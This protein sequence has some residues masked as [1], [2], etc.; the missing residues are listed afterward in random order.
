M[1]RLWFVCFAL[2]TFSSFGLASTEDDLK[3]LVSKMQQ[4][5]LTQNKN[6]Y[7]ELLDLS[8]P[9]FALEHSRFV[10]DWVKNPVKH[11]ELAFAL[12][13]EKTNEAQG[14]LTW[15]YQNKDGLN[16]TSNSLVVFHKLEGRWLYAGE[17]WLELKAENISVKFVPGLES[18]AQSILERLPEVTKHVATS[19]EF[20]SQ[21]TITVKIYDSR[22]SLTQSVGLSWKVFGGWNEPGEAIKVSSRLGR[23]VSSALLAHE[24]TH[25]Y[26]FEHFG[27]R[28]FPWWLDEGLAQDVASTYWNASDVNLTLRDVKTWEADNTLE[29]WE[30][31]SDLDTTPTNL[32]DYV[33]AQGFAFV[34]FIRQIYGQHGLNLW[35]TE[36]SSSKTKSL[37]DAAQ[38]TFGKSFVTLD[39][40]FRAWLKKQTLKLL[41]VNVLDFQCMVNAVATV[42]GLGYTL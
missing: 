22:E 34:H 37:S 19:L 13:E 33:Y 8:D 26:A 38:V 4:A 41:E 2:L 27:S 14:K 23:N 40:D 29:P 5:V 17:Y 3:S 11:L 39:Q 24:I 20:Q 32:W 16:I 7:H 18:Q 30:K 35:L 25:N 36:I 42:L 9:I 1:K 6:A 12:R 10:D 31:L 21:N 28:S 15:D